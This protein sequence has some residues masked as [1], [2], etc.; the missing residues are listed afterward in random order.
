MK[1]S[2]LARA[3]EGELIGLDCD[4]GSFCSDTRQLQA[5]DVFIALSGP[6][7]DANA[8][9]TQAAEAGA[10]AAIV[11]RMDPQAGIPQVLVSDTQR[12]LGLAAAAWRA[13]FTSLRRVAITGSAGKTSTKEMTA[14]IFALA[15]S[16]LATAGNFNNEIGVPLTLLRLRDHHQFGVFELGANHV[17]EIRYTSGLVQPEAAAITQIGT[18]HIGEFGGRDNIAAAKTEIYEGL[19]PFGTVVLNAD[20]DYADY[21]R[22]QAG[23]RPILTWSEQQSADVMAQAIRPGVWPGTWAFD[24]V[25]NGESLPVQ[26]RMLGRHQVSNALVAA[27]LAF[28]CGVASARIV[29]GLEQARP[30]A[31][32]TVLHAL[33]PGQSVIDDTYN[34]SP[35]AM[36]AAVDLLASLPGRRVLILG[37]MAELGDDAATYHTDL[38]AYARMRQIDRLYVT[39]QFAEQYALGFGD[40]TV[41]CAS[42][43]TLLAEVQQELEGVVT[44]LVK[45][46][47]S[48]RMERVVAGLEAQHIG[49]A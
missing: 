49:A 21:C 31:G 3:V 39:G 41:V 27:T 47:R 18:A 25:L 4:V 15:G 11:S 2:E 35:D 40:Q 26:L 38:G 32:R 10:V 44:L 37:D 16:T 24:L 1:L 34:A 5:G 33:R 23:D 29:K 13:R 17:G 48:A 22:H 6:R 7:F 42:T 45:G 9:V 30:L 19:G 43:D 46:S 12:A 14:S 20:C 28:A 36:R 8:L